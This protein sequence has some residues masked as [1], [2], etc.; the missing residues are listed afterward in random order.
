MLGNTQI[1][2]H[3]QATSDLLGVAVYDNASD[4]MDTWRLPESCA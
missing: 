1:D 3:I 2:F 4:G